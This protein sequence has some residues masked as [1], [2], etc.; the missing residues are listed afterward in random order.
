MKKERAPGSYQRLDLF[1]KVLRVL[2]PNL[3][4]DPFH[5][6]KTLR[7]NEESIGVCPHVRDFLS[8]RR[9]LIPEVN[10]KIWPLRFS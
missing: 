9:G 8:P 5:S 1:M 6:H 2:C 10:K 4:D 7:K 3:T